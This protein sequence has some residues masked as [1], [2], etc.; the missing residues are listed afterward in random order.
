[1]DDLDRMIVEFRKQH[2]IL[3]RKNRLSMWRRMFVGMF[4]PRW[5]RHVTTYGPAGG[6]MTCM[7]CGEEVL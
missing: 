4:F 6:A 2:P 1:V 5:C 7:D 3:W